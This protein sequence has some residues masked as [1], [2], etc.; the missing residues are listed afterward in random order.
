M[1]DN[2]SFYNFNSS[3]FK[4]GF[5]IPA[6]SSEFPEQFLSKTF[7]WNK[8]PNGQ[9]YQLDLRFNYSEEDSDGNIVNKHLTW[10]QP[11]EEFTG[12]LMSSKLEGIK[13]FNFL[14][15]NLVDIP[16]ITRRFQHIDI[17]MTV[18]T[19]DLNTYIKVNLPMTG[20]AQ[21]RPPFTNIN[22]GIGLFSS[23]YTHVEPSNIG[24]TQNTMDYLVN[25][26]GRNFQ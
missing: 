14:S 24:L 26:L 17:I 4:F 12:S 18:G 1:I 23:R 3:G 16:S 9:I 2:F 13:F 25:E 15:T 21:Q 5:Y 6:S 7:E 20:I 11:V 8:V 22:N 19:E 10:S